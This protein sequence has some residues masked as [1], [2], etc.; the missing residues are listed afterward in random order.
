VQYRHQPNLLSSRSPLPRIRNRD[1]DGLEDG[2]L[3]SMPPHRD[4]VIVTIIGRLEGYAKDGFR[5][6]R[7]VFAAWRRLS[8]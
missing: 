2:A 8:R 4:L 1:D 3:P 7:S 6:L 5:D